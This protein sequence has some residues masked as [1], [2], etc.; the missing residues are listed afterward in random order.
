[1]TEMG[2]LRQFN[3]LIGYSKQVLYL[4]RCVQKRKGEE[5]SIVSQLINMRIARSLE[6]IRKQTQIT[7]LPENSQSN[8]HHP[9]KG[10]NPH[11]RIITKA[12]SKGNIR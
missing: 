5:M 10:S 6:T 9:S 3:T 8:E 7:I 11:Q 1:M 2:S 12:N 4:T